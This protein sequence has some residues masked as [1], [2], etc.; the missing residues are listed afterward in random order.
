MTKG[1]YKSEDIRQD[2]LLNIKKLKERD[3]SEIRC[4]G[5][6]GNNPRAG[7][8]QCYNKA[9][10]YYECSLN[11]SGKIALCGVH[12]KNLKLIERIKK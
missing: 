7:W 6:T 4:E 5:S 3:P 12:S 10:G 2:G 8:G 1:Y 11:K 9:N